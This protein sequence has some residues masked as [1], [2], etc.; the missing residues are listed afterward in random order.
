MTFKN[1]FLVSCL[2][3][4]TFA[5]SQLEYG[6][7]AGIHLNASGNITDAPSDLNSVDN[8]KENMTG[9]FVGSYVSLDLLFL[10]VRPEIQFSYLNKNLI[11]YH[12]LNHDWKPLYL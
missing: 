12:F 5:F 9:Y 8:I 7:K 10:Y 1:T 11:H 3:V 6:V 2:L 4:S